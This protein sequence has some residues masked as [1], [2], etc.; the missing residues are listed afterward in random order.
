MDQLMP[1]PLSV[2]YFSDI[3]TGFTFLVTAHPG[4]PG[5]RA[6]KWLCVCEL[7]VVIRI[8]LQ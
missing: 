8:I 7:R 5:Q 6:A 3:Q 2:S 4:S 1:L